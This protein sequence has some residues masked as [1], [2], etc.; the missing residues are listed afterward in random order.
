MKFRFFVG[1]LVGCCFA[2]PA[3]TVFAHKLQVE[4]IVAVIRPQTGYL[5][6][7]FVGNVQ[8]VTQSVDIQ[9][10]EILGDGYVSAANKRVED[11]WNQ[12]FIVQQGKSTYKGALVSLTHDGG[13]DPTQTKFH[14]FLRYPVPSGA[15]SKAPL[16]VK[17]TLLSYLPNARIIVSLGGLQKTMAYGESISV[18]P[19]DVAVNVLINVRDFTRLGIEHI[20]TGPDHMLFILALLLVS[21]SLRQLVKTLTGFTIAHSITLILSALSVVVLPERITDILIAVSIIYVGAENLFLKSDTANKHRFWVA[22]A[23]GLVHG[24]GFSGV[25]RS[26]G[27][28]QGA[29]QFWCLLSFNLGV[30]IA[31]I[32]I[33]V[34]AFPLL[35]VWKRDSER[36]ARYGGMSWRNINNIASLGVCIAGT[37]WLIQR[38]FG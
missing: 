18:N 26:I 11:Y 30:E 35:M 23:F 20:F 16:I 13:L 6:A 4:P 2:L 32:L 8:D 21:T 24:F 9:D 36:R 22:S 25:L 15:D 29:A 5:S 12:N 38:A 31:Q 10:K 1:L 14:L 7:E 3:H 33:C 34:A 28:P 17:S 27:L 19:S 37:Y